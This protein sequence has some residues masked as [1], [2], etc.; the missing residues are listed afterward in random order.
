MIHEEKRNDLGHRGLPPT[1]PMCP[2]DQHV[3]LF[4][5]L[6]SL[7]LSMFYCSHRQ[8]PVLKV[9]AGP[10]ARCA[11][12]VATRSARGSI[13]RFPLHRVN[14][15]LEESFGP[16]GE[17]LL[18]CAAPRGAGCILYAD[19]GRRA[20][21]SRGF[22]G[23]AAAVGA[24]TGRPS[25]R[26]GHG[27]GQGPSPTEAAAGGRWRGEP[28]FPAAVAPTSSGA[29]G[30]GRPGSDEAARVPPERAIVQMMPR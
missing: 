9:P 14:S 25:A 26:K 5:C 27:E 13:L 21:G 1:S 4:V 22:L 17:V 10:L 19:P 23:I 20:R 11:S 12:R 7:P 6:Q 15:F 18:R 3:G 16:L 30:G 24:R 2:S 29:C 8:Y 28:S